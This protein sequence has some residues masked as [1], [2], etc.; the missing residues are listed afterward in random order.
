MVEKLKATND[1]NEY[2]ECKRIFEKAYED[3]IK[4]CKVKSLDPKVGVLTKMMQINQVIFHLRSLYE[5]N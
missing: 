5:R 1:Q 4:Y 2:K 3:W